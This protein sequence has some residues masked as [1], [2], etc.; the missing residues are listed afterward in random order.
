MPNRPINYSVP[1]V[2]E[3]TSR[4]ERAYD[5]FSLMLRDRI[6]FLGTPV[7]DEVANTIVANSIDIG[8]GL[9]YGAFAGI[10]STDS[11][12]TVPGAVNYY[13]IANPTGIN[14][15]ISAASATR[16]RASPVAGS[17]RSRN[18]PDCGSTSSPL[19][20]SPYSRPVATAIRAQDT[21]FRAGRRGQT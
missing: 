2:V 15:N 18:S 12:S 21:G 16:A 9:D 6:I 19:M 1:M 13:G 5:I 4:G 8:V 14:G 7:T 20:K 10:T 11:Y 3:Q 17:F